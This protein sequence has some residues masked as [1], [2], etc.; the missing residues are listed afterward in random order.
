MYEVSRKQD[1]GP[2]I[3]RANKISRIS[4]KMDTGIGDDAHPW[5]INDKQDT[6]TRQLK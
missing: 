4:Q 1:S 5:D 2:I 6:T 3:F